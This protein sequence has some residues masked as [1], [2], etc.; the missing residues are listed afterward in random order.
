M[1]IDGYCSFKMG[2]RELGIANG[3]VCKD[4][5]KCFFMTGI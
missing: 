1:R 3:G 2:N 4:Q 5:A